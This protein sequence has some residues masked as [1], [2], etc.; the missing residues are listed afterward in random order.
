MVVELDDGE[1]CPCGAAGGWVA[2]TMLV[3]AGDGPTGGE[4]MCWWGCPAGD[5]IG[6]FMLAAGERICWMVVGERRPGEGMDTGERTLPGQGLRIGPG[7]E[8]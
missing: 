6:G 7:L 3:G 2:G 1:K 4:W 8:L 5:R